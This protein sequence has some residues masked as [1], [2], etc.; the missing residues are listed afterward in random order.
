MSRTPTTSD[1]ESHIAPFFRERNAI[2]VYELLKSMHSVPQREYHNLSHVQQCLSALDALAPSGPP[3]E[4]IAAIWF[5]DCVYLPGSPHNET[6]SAAIAQAYAPLLGFGTDTAET[7]ARSVMATRSHSPDETG[8]PALV[9]D[10]DLS[11]LGAHPDDYAAYADA[12]RQE[13]SHVESDAFHQGRLAFVRSMLAREHIFV[14]SVGQSLFEDSARTN[15]STEVQRLEG[16]TH[17]R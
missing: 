5:H 10:A 7:I 3:A 1:G 17:A 12:I 8:I 11:I 6:A 4:A 13:W 9:V 16:L 15:L 14:T 2:M